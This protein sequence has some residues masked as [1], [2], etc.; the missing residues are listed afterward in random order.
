MWHYEGPFEASTCEGILSVPVS[1]L[2]PAEHYTAA[3]VVFNHDSSFKSK[4]IDI[5][6]YHIS[7]F[8]CI[9]LSLHIYLQWLRWLILQY[10]L[11]LLDTTAVQRVEVTQGEEC[12][13]VNCYFAQGSSAQGCVVVMKI[14]NSH[15]SQHLHIWRYNITLDTNTQSGGIHVHLEPITTAIDIQV[16]DW[17]ENGRLGSLSI[18]PL[19][20]H[21]P[22]MTCMCSVSYALV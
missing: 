6:K 11:L 13:L 4:G 7:Y 5:C 15:T 2:K 16:Y 21:S 3:V 18:P 22:D 14:V 1:G 8:Y 19:I 17:Q 12:I 9:N 10:I 20:K